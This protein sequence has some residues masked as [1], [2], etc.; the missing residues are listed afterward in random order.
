MSDA[1]LIEVDDLTFRYRRATE[2]AVRDLTLRVE[3]G[4]VLLVA[5]PSGCGKSTLIRAINGLIPHSYRGE[6]A[7]A[8]RIQGRPTS[9]LRLREISLVIGTL[10]Q[11]P[12]KQ[13][14]GP[15]VESEL[16]FG[17][18][19]AGTAPS[20]IRSRI[21]EVVAETGIDS[22]RRTRDRGRSPAASGSSWPWRGRSCPDRAATSWMSRWRTSTPP[23][24]AI[25]WSCC[26]TSPMRGT[27]SSWSS[28]G[29]RRHWR[30]APIGSWPWTTA[31][32]PTSDRWTGSW[33]SPTR[34]SVKL[35]F[36]IVLERARRADGLPPSAPA[37]H[38]RSRA[39][40]AGVRGSSRHAR[41]TAGPA[42][43]RCRAR[44]SPG[45]CGPGSER[46]RQDD[47]VPNAP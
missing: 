33:R 1:P 14:V 13:I 42:R 35:P 47:A 43:R 10:L 2:P 45:R 28:I 23:L 34:S 39:G 6:V 7:G 8:V 5:G 36:E 46:L 37:R 16:A 25:S 17:P 24:P 18:E 4:E 32:R 12:A 31:A 9:E 26:G 44:G 27:R 11:D 40:A 15:T 30:C 3:P 22:P 29:S 41:G 38:R 20:D 19:N 21:R